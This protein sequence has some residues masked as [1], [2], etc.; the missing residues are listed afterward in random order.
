MVI[1][2]K[3]EVITLGLGKNVYPGDTIV[4]P[5]KSKTKRI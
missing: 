4:V 1:S 2:N 5:F 3:V